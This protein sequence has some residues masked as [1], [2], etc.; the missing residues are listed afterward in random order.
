MLQG[1]VDLV[2]EVTQS[3]LSVSVDGSDESLRMAD[4]VLLALGVVFREQLHRALAEEPDLALVAFLLEWRQ[5][6]GVEWHEALIC[7]WLEQILRHLC[8]LPLLE[9]AEDK[10][11]PLR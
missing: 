7:V 5:L 3:R 9:M 8:F 6:F 4:V 11:N 10:V 2:A 1:V